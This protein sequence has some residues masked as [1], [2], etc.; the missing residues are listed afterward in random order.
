MEEDQHLFDLKVWLHIDVWDDWVLVV[1]QTITPVKLEFQRIDSY[2]AYWTIWMGCGWQVK[3]V[4]GVEIKNLKH[5]SQ[6]VEN[7]SM[8]SLRFDLDD[9]R[10]IVLNYRLAKIATSRIL[11]RHRIPSAMSRDLIQKQDSSEAE[12]ACLSWVLVGKLSFVI[13]TWK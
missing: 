4:N 6:L 8:E 10:V 7:C 13:M 3:K 9:E 12:L 11:K 1:Y 5:F 2:N